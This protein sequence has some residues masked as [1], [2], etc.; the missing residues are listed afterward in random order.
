VGFFKLESI[1]ADGFELMNQEHT[2]YS[3]E[4]FQ[5]FLNSQKEAEAQIQSGKVFIASTTSSFNEPMLI[6]GTPVA[7]E[8]GL[9]SHRA[10]G[11]FRL[12]RLQASFEKSHSLSV[13][14]I[15]HTGKVIV[16]PEEK[17]TIK[18]TDFSQSKAI[19]QFL[20]ND[21][22]KRQQYVDEKLFSVS[23]TLYGPIVVGE[24][25]RFSILRPS[26]LA[27][28]TSFFILGIILSVSFFLSVLFCH[29]ISKNIEKLTHLV[30]RI[31]DG[32]FDVNAGREITT[33][34]EIGLLANAFDDMTDGL[35]E[36][37]KIKTMFRD[38]F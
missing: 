20:S 23:R 19:K 4:N 27:K 9:I 12:N 11:I 30:Y 13:Y 33:K 10:W 7:K 28:E 34:D 18:G 15:D 5:L 29:S 22:S 38:E 16:H 17:H 35:K 24:V 31:A 1:G 32:D 37:D 3:K 8:N 25:S 36:R 2:T 6:I 14:L 21:I 26:M